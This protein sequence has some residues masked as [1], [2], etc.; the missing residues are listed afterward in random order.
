MGA[1]PWCGKARREFLS[2]LPTSAITVLLTV[3]KGK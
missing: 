2:E 3:I 1:L